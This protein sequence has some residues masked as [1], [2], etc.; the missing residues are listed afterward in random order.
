MSNGKICTTLARQ[1]RSFS[2]TRSNSSLVKAPIQLFGL[3]G[4]YAHAI[5]SA[6]SKTNKLDAVDKDFQGLKNL[7]ATEKKLVEILKTPTL[8]KEQKKNAVNELAV[9]RN[10]SEITVNTL[11]LL[12]ENGRLGRLIGVVQAFGKLM[13]AHKGEVNAVITTAKP[14]DAA[15]RKELDAIL[16]TLVKKGSKLNVEVKTNADILGGMIVEVGDRYIDMSIASKVKVYSD[17][18]KQTL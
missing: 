9:K 14:I 17:I 13:S 16:Q 18:V 4:R 1:V 5:Y 6:A 8:T 15:Q 2:T 11:S 12:A 10:A 3:E 7:F